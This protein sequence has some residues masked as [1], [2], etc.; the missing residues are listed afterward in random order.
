M[1]SGKDLGTFVGDDKLMGRC[2]W[3]NLNQRV[4]KIFYISN[5]WNLLQQVILPSM[6]MFYPKKTSILPVSFGGSFL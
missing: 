3:E 2:V 1:L 5:K 6:K 4:T